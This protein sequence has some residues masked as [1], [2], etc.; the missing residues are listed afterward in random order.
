MTKQYSQLFRKKRMCCLVRDNF[1]CQ[2]PGCTE[3]R[4]HFLTVHHI[5]PLSAG[6]KHRVSNL[7]TLCFDHHDALHRPVGSPAEVMTV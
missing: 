2:H 4:L 1:K 6:G 3:T 5:K 7:V